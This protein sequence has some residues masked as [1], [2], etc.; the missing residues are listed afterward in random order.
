M[1]VFP[2]ST[3]GTGA[4]DA[5]SIPSS[6]SS[7]QEKAGTGF[8][9]MLSSFIEEDRLDYSG[10]PPGFAALEEGS[11]TLG[12]SRADLFKDAL[13]RRNVPEENILG[14][15]QYMQSG[16]PLTI[17][18]AFNALAGGGRMTEELGDKERDTLKVLFGKMGFSK[19]ETEELTGLSDDGK[20]SA[21]LKRIKAG[22]GKLEGTLDI[23]K[24]EFT[25]L[26]KGLDLS[27]GMQKKLS[28]LFGEGG[29]S[30]SGRD[31]EALLAEAGNEYAARE[32]AAR[33]TRAHMRAAMEDALQAAE[34]QDQA[35]LV[36]SRHGN[37][38]SEQLE[39]FMQDSVLKKTGANDI[40]RD[41]SE[42]SKQF[43]RNQDDK[44]QAWRSPVAEAQVRSK[45]RTGGRE[46]SVEDAATKI[47]QGFD[48][49]AG[50]MGTQGASGQARNLDSMARAHRQ[51]IFSQVEQ[52]I[53]QNAHNGSQRIM[54]QLAPEALGRIT[55]TLSLYQGEVKASIM[56]EEPES[57]QVL[58]EQLA[59]LKA[60]LEAEGIKVKE[61]DVQTQ[62][63]DNSFAEQWSN[64]QEHN[65]MRDNQ[66]RDRLMRLSRMRREHTAEDPHTGSLER[67]ATST[68]K[69]GLHIVA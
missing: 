10:R 56:A 41:L 6:V 57:A 23:D 35:A 2:F 16:A 39:S 22:L 66:E 8:E 25:A 27:P 37:R 34:I 50:A 3:D 36:E 45:F 33:F 12:S 31:L 61:L 15:E 18:K 21:L 69:T 67:T 28:R 38:R 7:F 5:N 54:L 48:I 55:L 17:G 64:P 49:S 44:S 65:L 4:I 47:L 11:G 63:K 62:T 53:L 51:E 14:L 43:S 42:D 52:G 13:R 1:Q 24:E 58:Q 9:G 29:G 46:D 60:S 68:E 59:E 19:D 40:K 32:R 20:G 30:V 26:L